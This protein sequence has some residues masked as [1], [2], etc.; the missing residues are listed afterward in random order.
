LF[1]SGRSQQVGE[2]VNEERLSQLRL[3]RRR[4]IEEEGLE[5]LQTEKG[6]REVVGLQPSDDKQGIRGNLIEGT[7]GD[8]RLRGRRLL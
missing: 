2:E 4:G 8:R 1:C 5:I 7:R 6:E 3:D